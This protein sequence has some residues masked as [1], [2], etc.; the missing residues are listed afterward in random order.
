MGVFVIKS[1]QN[2]LESLKKSCFV[3]SSV[4]QDVMIEEKLEGM[5]FNTFVITDNT[6]G[7]FKALPPTEILL[8]DGVEIFDYHHKYMP[9]AANK[10]TPPQCS[11]ED[12]KKIQE[13]CVATAKALSFE[14]IAR[15][16]GFLTKDGRVVILDSNPISGMAPSSFGFRQAAEIGMGHG[17]LI[18]H[19]IAFELI[20]LPE[21][22]IRLS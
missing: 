11:Q 3:S 13:T 6:T 19:L 9:G 7:E 12:I 5:E 10:R 1:E 8:R 15:I 4:G 21:L 20:I 16:D 2:L 17:K 22:I 14:N 18:N